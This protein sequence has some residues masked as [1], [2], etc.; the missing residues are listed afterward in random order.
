MGGGVNTWGGD[1][2]SS[3]LSFLCLD[4]KVSLLSSGDMENIHFF[5]NKQKFLNIFVKAM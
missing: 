5:C 3:V 4:A 2:I 1:Y